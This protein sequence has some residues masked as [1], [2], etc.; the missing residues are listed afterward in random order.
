MIALITSTEQMKRD[1][2]KVHNLIH[3]EPALLSVK[4]WI[5]MYRKT[6]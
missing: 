1:Q 6:F 3:G 2:A 4:G 5:L